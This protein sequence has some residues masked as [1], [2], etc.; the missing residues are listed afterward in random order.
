MNDRLDPYIN[1]PLRTVV[2]IHINAATFAPI[3]QAPAMPPRAADAADFSTISRKDN[4]FFAD[5]VIDVVS[6][7]LLMIDN[8]IRVFYLFLCVYELI[9]LLPISSMAECSENVAA[10][11][12][13]RTTLPP[14]FKSNLSILLPGD[15]STLL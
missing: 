12:Q 3:A 9:Y 1:H 4:C 2:R 5:A 11:F 6:L 7:L 10:L 13:T 14:G 15:I 8:A